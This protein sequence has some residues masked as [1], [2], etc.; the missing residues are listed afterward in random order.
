MEM[1][2]SECGMRSRDKR[3][4]RNGGMRIAAFVQLVDLS[5]WITGGQGSCARNYSEIVLMY[6]SYYVMSLG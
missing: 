6:T 5:N 2:N 1:R 4:E 3:V